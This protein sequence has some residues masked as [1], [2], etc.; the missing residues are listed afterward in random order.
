M[1]S[2]S[3]RA[4]HKYKVIDRNDVYDQN[5]KPC[6][7]REQFV[8]MYKFDDPTRPT[9]WEKESGRDFFVMRIA[10]MYLIAAEAEHKNG[11]N[12]KAAE[13]L[14]V[15]RTKRAIAGEEDRMKIS[16]S[17]VDID[18]ILDERARELAGEQQRWFDLKRTDKLV[19]RVKKYNPDAV[20]VNENHKLRPFPQAQLDAITN[21]NEFKQN[22][23]YN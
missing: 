9:G 16:S 14:N 12:D 18:F 22:N 23:G 21:K 1:I 17:D 8:S 6:G 13:Y 7:T 3:E 2:E 11:N 19:E 20:T 10:E 5:G 15:L 4:R